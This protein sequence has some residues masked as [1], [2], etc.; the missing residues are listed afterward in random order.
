MV[1]F[2]PHDP[3]TQAFDEERQNMYESSHAPTWIDSFNPSDGNDVKRVLNHVRSVVLVNRQLVDLTLS[4]ERS[5][6]RGSTSQSQFDN[7]L[8]VA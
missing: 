2:E 3:I 6:D 1:A 8:R 5:A 7:Q 4:L